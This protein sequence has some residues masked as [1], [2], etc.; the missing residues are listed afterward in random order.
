MNMTKVELLNALV[1]RTEE[2]TKDLLLPVKV[3]R[4][5]EEPSERT[6]AVYKQRIPDMTQPSKKAPYIIH[7]I[8]NSRNIQH[9]GEYVAT[10]V[11]VRSIFCVYCEDEQEGSLMLLNV[12]ERMRIS[13]LKDPILRKQFECVLTEEDGGGL[14]DLVYP[15]NIAPYYIGEMITVWDMPKVKRE[16]PCIW[17]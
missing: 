7:Q 15:D 1:E 11:T 4:E 16:V 12:M 3:Q 8:V 17:Q 6:P 5:G 10:T 2:I 9:R 14:E 13:F